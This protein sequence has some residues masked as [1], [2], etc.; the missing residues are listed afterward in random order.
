VKTVMRKL[1]CDVVP[2]H[3]NWPMEWVHFTLVQILV[4]NLRAQQTVFDM[5]WGK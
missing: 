2:V 1:F 4:A 3:G 5:A